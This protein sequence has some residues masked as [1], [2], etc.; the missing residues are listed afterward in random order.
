MI[1]HRGAPV[2]LSNCS[3]RGCV[4]PQVYPASGA[5]KN[6]LVEKANGTW[7]PPQSSP[8]RPLIPLRCSSPGARRHRTSQSELA[9]SCVQLVSKERSVGRIARIPIIRSSRRRFRGWCCEGFPYAGLQIGDSSPTK[10]VFVGFC[11]LAS[12]K[13]KRGIQDILS[14]CFHFT[15]GTQRK[16]FFNPKEAYF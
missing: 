4:G 9:D 12:K 3:R 6:W 15:I 8:S 1:N 7:R 11:C 2:L 14:Q 13:G 5:K 10:C 16:C